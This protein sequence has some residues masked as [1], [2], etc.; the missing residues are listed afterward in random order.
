MLVMSARLLSGSITENDAG[1][2]EGGGGGGGG[3]GGDVL[4][5][6]VMFSP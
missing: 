1:G 2:V 3:R 6:V 4:T 5:Y